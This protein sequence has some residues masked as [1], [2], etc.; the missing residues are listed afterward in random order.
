RALVTLMVVSIP[1]QAAPLPVRPA[2]Y[3]RML[4]VCI[5]MLPI[6]YAWVAIAPPYRRAGLHV[7]YL[8]CFT[9]LVLA[10]AAHLTLSPQLLASTNTKAS[11]TENFATRASRYS[12]RSSGVTFA[13]SRRTIAASGRS[14]HF[15][16]GTATPAA[17]FTAGWPI[18][19]FSSATE[20]IH[21]PPDL[22]R[23][24]VRS[25]ICRYPSGSMVTTS[26]VLN[27][28]SR[29]HRSADP[30]M[31]VYEDAT[32]GP[33]TC[34]SPC[35]LPSHGT[36]RPDSSTARTSTSGAGN[37]CLARTATFAS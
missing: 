27:Q 35:V 21:S 29:V 22:M 8:G 10:V 28:P 25:V 1:L 36:S 23:S 6:G 16:C 20:L 34:N 32:A 19:S 33:R 26:P 9:A 13:P 2:M 30:S 12:R 15:G 3:D 14:D 18:S 4:R 31:S 24:L 17:S 37:P 7:V 5:W 11:G